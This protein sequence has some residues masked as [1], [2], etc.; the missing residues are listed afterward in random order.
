[1]DAGKIDD[2]CGQNDDRYLEENEVLF[3]RGPNPDKDLYPLGNWP[4]MVSIQQIQNGRSSHWCCG[5]ILTR[6][7]VLTAAHCTFEPRQ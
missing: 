3:V 4:W 6:T 2:I 1:M 7:H 5:T